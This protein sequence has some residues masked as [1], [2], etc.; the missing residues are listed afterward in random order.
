MNGL[1][2]RTEKTERKRDDGRREVWDKWEESKET[3]KL[4]RGAHGHSVRIP[5]FEAIFFCLETLT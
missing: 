3:L 4:P 2:G 1:D 5:G